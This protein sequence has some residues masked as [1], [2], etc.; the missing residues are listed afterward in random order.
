[1]TKGRASLG[2]C[3]TQSKVVFHFPLCLL[4]MWV[5]MCVRV[6]A[7]V[8]EWSVCMHPGHAWVILYVDSVLKSVCW[9]EFMCV[10]LYKLVLAQ[11]KGN[12]GEWLSMCFYATDQGECRFR[13]LQG[14]EVAGSGC[15]PGVL[16][17]SSVMGWLM[18]P[19]VLT[20]E[21]SS[22]KQVATC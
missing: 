21:R 3:K 22:Q 18:W 15:S 6:R 14:D 12:S 1:M 20:E 16:L 13:R 8:Y 4:S 11:H 10:C 7:C 19:G 5:A 17:L 9:A 2:I